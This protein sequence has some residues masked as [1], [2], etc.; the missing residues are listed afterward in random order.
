MKISDYIAER[1]THETDVVFGVTGGTVVN[2]FD[3]IHKHGPRLIPMHHE[4][5]AAMG[6]EAYARANENFGVVLVSSEPGATNA[7]TGVVGAWLDSTPCTPYHL[8]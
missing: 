1:L 7:I 2:L 4:Q 5:A 8:V 6:A 3:S